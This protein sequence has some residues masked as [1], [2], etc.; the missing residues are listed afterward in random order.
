VDYEKS[1]HEEPVP[2]INSTINSEDPEEILCRNALEYAIGSSPE[3]T[4]MVRTYRNMNDNVFDLPC[5]ANDN[6]V[7]N[8]CDEETNS[9]NFDCAYMPS[10]MNLS[11]SFRNEHA[12]SDYKSIQEPMEDLEV[13][14]N[15]ANS[16]PELTLNTAG[17]EAVETLDFGED[18]D[19]DVDI[20]DDQQMVSIQE[21]ERILSQM[22]LESAKFRHLH[23]DMLKREVERL[24]QGGTHD[25]SSTVD[26]GATRWY[27][28]VEAFV[29]V[30][31][32]DANVCIES[33]SVNV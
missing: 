11:A 22:K 15:D 24:A 16:A 23:P 20:C 12:E 30:D 9:I 18:E 33:E 13:D 1:N 3:R 29:D 31:D 21:M 5:I 17:G 6:Q 25:E 32:E 4:V 2:Q 19:D 10:G 8:F 27:D 14:E 28:D 7:D 26:G